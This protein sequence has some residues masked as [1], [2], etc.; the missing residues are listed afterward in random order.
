MYWVRIASCKPSIAN[1]VETAKLKS[2][3]LTSKNV[4]LMN[5]NNAFEKTYQSFKIQPKISANGL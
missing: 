1:A 2:E 5:F 3:K 4:I